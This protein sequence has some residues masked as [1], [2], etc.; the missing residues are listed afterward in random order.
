MCGEKKTA[1]RVTFLEQHCGSITGDIVLKI[2]ASCQTVGQIQ[3]VLLPPAEV[4]LSPAVKPE[5]KKTM[6]QEQ[7][8]CE[9]N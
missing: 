3:R 9:A 4:T 2:S 6:R 5:K 1:D 8:L 7:T